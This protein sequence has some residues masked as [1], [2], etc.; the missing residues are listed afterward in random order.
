MF[1]NAFMESADRWGFPRWAAV[2]FLVLPLAGVP[3]L[4]V[5][6]ALSVDAFGWVFDDDRIVE[7]AQFFFFAGAA[8]ASAWIAAHRL[9]NG[10][11][12]QALLF[13]LAALAMVFVAGEEI[14]WGQRL[15]GLQTPEQLREINLQEELTVH[16]ISGVLQFFNVALFLTSAWAMVAEP[17]AR[18]LHLGRRW[19][20]ADWLFAPPLFLAAAFSVMVGFRLVRFVYRESSYTITSFSE[21]AELSYSAAV[22]VFLVLVIRHLASTRTEPIP[23]S[24]ARS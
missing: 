1:L 4:V 5:I 8:I 23:E 19:A 11:R 14:A 21:W 18:R 12:W 7:W 2:A 22:L 9:R 10:H 15:L 17:V 24:P 6:R 20:E 16:N 3:V 13:A